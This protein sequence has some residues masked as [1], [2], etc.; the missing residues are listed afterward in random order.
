[1][2]KKLGA[3]ALV[4][5]VVGGVLAG[6]GPA[7]ATDGGSASAEKD[8]KEFAIS[9][10]VTS[11]QQVILQQRFEGLTLEEQLAFV[12]DPSSLIEFT[13]GTQT[14]SSPSEAMAATS[15]KQLAARSRALEINDTQR[16]QL[17]GITVASFNLNYRYEANASRVTRNLS[18]NGSFSGIGLTGSVSPS[19]YVTSNGR[20]TCQ[21]RTSVNAVFKGSPIQFTKL[22]SFTTAQG[23][24]R[25]GK[26]TISNV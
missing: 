15:S 13:S 7:L 17:L 11:E 24:P 22:H 5:M 6:G 8:F 10:G 3:L 19:N 12:E 14:T 20:G 23:N 1:M 9:L 25:T 21:V 26:A 2:Q 4:T 16:A 18:C